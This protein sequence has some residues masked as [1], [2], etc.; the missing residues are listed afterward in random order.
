MFLGV[1][2]ERTLKNYLMDSSKAEFGEEVIQR[3]GKGRKVFFLVEP[4]VG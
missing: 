2:G 4:K 1:V 3:H